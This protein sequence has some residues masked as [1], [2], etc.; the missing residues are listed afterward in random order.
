MRKRIISSIIIVLSIA[1]IGACARKQRPDETTEQFK[2]YRRAFHSAEVIYGIDALGDQ[3]EIIKDGGLIPADAARGAIDYTDQILSAADE[4]ALALE[5]GLPGTRFDK[6]RDVIKRFKLAEANGAI[7]FGSTKAKAKF[8]AALAT[9][10][11]SINLVEAFN[12]GNNERV[13]SLSAQRAVQLRNMRDEG[14]E[15][16]WID[17]IVRLTQLAN[18]ISALSPLDAP[19]IW[20][21]V[22]TR[23]EQ[24]HQK[25]SVR[26]MSWN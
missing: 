13:K 19:Q 16:W 14:T 20:P 1:I 2:Q 25:N 11:V 22:H 17:T 3:I 12:V 7:K 10:E 23:S 18:E 21:Q 24:S 8:Y 5:Q 15:P 26:K 4:V 9:V 6:I